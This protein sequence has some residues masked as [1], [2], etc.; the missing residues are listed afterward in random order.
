MK[1]GERRPPSSAKTYCTPIPLNST[2]T[3]TNLL[4]EQPY[5]PFI[6]PGQTQLSTKTS[7]NVGTR[8]THTHRP[9]KAA[10]A[11]LLLTCGQRRSRCSSSS[12]RPLARGRRRRRRR[13]RRRLRGGTRTGT[14]T[15]GGARTVG[16]GRRRPRQVRLRHHRNA[17]R[18]RQRL[19]LRRGVAG[20][21]RRWYRRYNGHG[22]RPSD[23]VPDELQNLATKPMTA[24]G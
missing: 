17:A 11:P 19:A 14:R 22:D 24:D 1:H 12:G 4:H 23:L 3:S 13:T 20:V 21:R 10:A 9:N 16:G 5:S 6:S 18:W 2:A 8:H 7:E 15:G